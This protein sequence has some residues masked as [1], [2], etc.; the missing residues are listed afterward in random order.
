MEEPPRV[1]R[2][3]CVSLLEDVLTGDSDLS[4]RCEYYRLG[5]SDRVY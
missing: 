4:S 3:V 5:S 2:W 1:D